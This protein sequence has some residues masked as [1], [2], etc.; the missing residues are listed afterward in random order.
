MHFSTLFPNWIFVCVCLFLQQPATECA[1]SSDCCSISQPCRAFDH[2][3][4]REKNCHKQQCHGVGMHKEEEG[5]TV[6]AVFSVIILNFEQWFLAFFEQSLHG[7]VSFAAALCL[8]KS[9][10]MYDNI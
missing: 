7:G 6:E 3:T 1:N 9:V 2:A 5:S 8:R 10:V 4:R